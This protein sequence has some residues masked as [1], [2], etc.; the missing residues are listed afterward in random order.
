MLRHL[1]MTD[2]RMARRFT[3]RLL[4]AVEGAVRDAERRHGGEI[5][6][7]IENALPP[8]AVLAGTTP[9]A[10]ALEVFSLL[11]VWDTERNEGVL[12]YVLCADQAIEIVADRAYNG[13]VDADAWARVCEAMRTRFA[14]GE[15]REGLL[16]GIA[17]VS[18]L[19]AAHFPEPAAS[20]LPDRPALL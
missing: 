18:A 4:D 7:A 20:S 2:A 11:R 19:L 3:P 17:A 8:R 13:R 12:I 5:R 9:R 10:R 14:A 6:V 15:Y 16:G 1:A